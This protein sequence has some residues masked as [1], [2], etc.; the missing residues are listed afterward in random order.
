VIFIGLQFQVVIALIKINTLVGDVDAIKKFLQENRNID[1][2]YII[3]AAD[4]EKT[5]CGGCKFNVNVNNGTTLLHWAVKSSQLKT[6]KFL[7]ENGADINK[8]RNDGWYSQK[9]AFCS[10][11]RTALHYAAVSGDLEITSLLIK[12]VAFHT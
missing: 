6:I 10:L 5:N 11:P 8:P 12:N 3:E 7:L 4:G 2:P 9:L 1:E